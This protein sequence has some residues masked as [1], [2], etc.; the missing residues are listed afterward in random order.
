[1][2]PSLFTRASTPILYRVTQCGERFAVAI[3]PA[4]ALARAHA[5][6]RACWARAGAWAR[7][8]CRVDAHSLPARR[9]SCYTGSPMSVVVQ[10]YGGSSVAAVAKLERVAE[11]VVTT[12]KAGT[13]VVVVV[14]AMGKTTDQL[15]SLAHQIDA[16]PPRRELDMLLTT[17]ERVSMALLS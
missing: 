2:L 10:K 6:N 16:S 17:G 5:R 14:S 1:A 3:E 8:G 12:R 11:K 4:P 7:A 9:P 15:L 13:D